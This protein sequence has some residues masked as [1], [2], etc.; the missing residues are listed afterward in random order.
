M[1]ELARFGMIHLMVAVDAVGFLMHGA[2]NLQAGARARPSTPATD[3]LSS[4]RVS[5]ASVYL[6]V[7]C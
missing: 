7:K 2:L 4:L 6:G 5:L 1:F 3:E